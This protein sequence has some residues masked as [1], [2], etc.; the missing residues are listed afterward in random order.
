MTNRE[1]RLSIF[2][3]FEADKIN[4]SDCGAAAGK[5]PKDPSSKIY[6]FCCDGCK[7]PKIDKCSTLTAKEVR[8]LD[9]RSRR[10]LKF[11]CNN[12][13]DFYTSKLMKKII[14]ERDDIIASATLKLFG[15]WKGNRLKKNTS[16][17][18]TV[19]C[20][21]DITKSINKPAMP[22]IPCLILKPVEKQ[23][24]VQTRQ[25]LVTKA[26]PANLGI[27]ITMMKTIKDGHLLVK[28]DSS[29][30]KDAM[31]REIQNSLGAKY[32]IEDTKLKK[33]LVTI[34]NLSIDITKGDV[35]LA[36]HFADDTSEQLF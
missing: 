12:C 13:S 15:F 18:V 36:L 20:Y 33:P 23:E 4:C 6:I 10:T 1:V 11:W 31:E 14:P 35:T 19:E 32:N 27:G 26:N 25:E 3:S 29:K 8:V 17:N 22:N 5:D 16:R 30:S 9:F 24:G 21:E 7:S 34:A 28:Y 2:I